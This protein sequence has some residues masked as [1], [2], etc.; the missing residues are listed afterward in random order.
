MKLKSYKY[1]LI[2][3][4]IL[5]IVIRVNGQATLP[6]E[7]TSSSLKEQLKYL[8]DHTRIYENYR[9]IR[10]DIFQKIKGNIV[11]SLSADKI[12][13]DG[14]N[15]RNSALK[16]TYDSLNIKLETTTS[17]L[18]DMTATKN[19]IR[20]LGMEINKKGYNSI[21]WT[22][23]IVMVSLLVAGFIIFKRNLFIT[24]KTGKELKELREEFEAYR[25]STRIAR[26]KMEMAHF[27]E[28]KKLKSK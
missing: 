5:L 1:I 15:D 4:A 3:A 23:I 28:I 10:E 17:N 6:D 9:A 22:I 20:L 8:E 27:N 2:F 13:I 25:Q 19:S 21:M 7:L 26:E 18:N 14:L 16:F 11:D 24:I 12:R